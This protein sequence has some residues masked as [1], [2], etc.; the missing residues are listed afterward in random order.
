MQILVAMRVLIYVLLRC[1]TVGPSAFIFPSSRRSKSPLS[2]S[3]LNSG[4]SS[5][6]SLRNEVDRSCILD[7]SS[8]ALAGDVGAKSGKSEKL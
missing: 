6:L 8:K 3:P 5:S 2:G 4:L 1:I 7:R